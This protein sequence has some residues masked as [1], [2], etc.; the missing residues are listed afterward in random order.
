MRHVD[1]VHSVSAKYNF[2]ESISGNFDHLDP[3]VNV[4]A[5]STIDEIVVDVVLYRNRH[6]NQIT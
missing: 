4:M 5:V 1:R 3:N 6:G 2:V